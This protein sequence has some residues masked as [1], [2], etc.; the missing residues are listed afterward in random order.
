VPGQLPPLDGMAVECYLSALKD[1][2]P[3]CGATSGQRQLGTKMSATARLSAPEAALEEKP[4][5]VLIA[6]DHPLM[7]AGIRRA[8]EH[9]GTID[10]VGQASSGEEL[11]QLAARRR[12]QVVVMDMRMPGVSG[13]DC[14]RE[15]R[16]AWPEVKVV[17]LSANEDRA[18]IDSALAAG[19]SAYVLKTVHTADI[20]GVLRQAA[21]GSVFHPRSGSALTGEDAHGREPKLLTERERTILEAVAAGMTTAAIS[22]ELWVSE[23]T[24]KFHLTNIYRKLEVRNRAGAVRYALEH[25]LVNG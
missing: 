17:V 5:K 7:L 22:Q 21:S 25:G 4:L 12:P 18:S 14:I 11:L 13:N 9:S 15:I 23:H 2:A 24:V 16:G 19:A 10:V 6:D 3:I 8:L 20:A 1:E